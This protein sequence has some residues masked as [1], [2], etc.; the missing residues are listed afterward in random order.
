M[1][2]DTKKLNST[3]EEALIYEHI[4]KIKE[5]NKIVDRIWKETYAESD[6]QSIQIQCI[7]QEQKN[8]EKSFYYEVQ[9]LQKNEQPLFLKYFG[10]SG[11]KVLACLVIR[12]ALAEFFQLECQLFALDEPTTHLDSVN[13]TS[14][15]KY[16]H[17]L[18]KWKKNDK[19]F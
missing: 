15:A 10:S 6:I 5:L 14:L 16:L 18:A 19:N 8:Q 7:L 2:A 13:S 17:N 11:Q 3:L 4:K 9:C 12:L 1:I